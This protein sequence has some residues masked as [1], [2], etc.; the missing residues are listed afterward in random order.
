MKNHHPRQTF[1]LAPYFFPGPAV[2]SHFFHSRISTAYR[3]LRSSCWLTDIRLFDFYRKRGLGLD[4]LRPTRGP[5]AA[6]S[7]VF[8]ARF[9]LSL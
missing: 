3:F 5:H 7:K 9:R 2:A 6:Q 4:Q 1:M 8:A